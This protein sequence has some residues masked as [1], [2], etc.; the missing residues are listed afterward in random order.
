MARSFQLMHSSSQDTFRIGCTAL[1][2]RQMDSWI[3]NVQQMD[4]LM[5]TYTGLSKECCQLC[6]LYLKL[7]HRKQFSHALVHTW[8]SVWPHHCCGPDHTLTRM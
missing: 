1:F 7:S 6:R 5:D 4:K 3:D 8:Y 2:N